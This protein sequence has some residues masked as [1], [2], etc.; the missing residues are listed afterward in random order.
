MKLKCSMFTVLFHRFCL[1]VSFPRPKLSRSLLVHFWA[2]PTAPVDFCYQE[3][4]T[5]ARTSKWPASQRNCTPPWIQPTSLQ[6]NTT[7]AGPA[8]NPRRLLPLRRKKPLSEPVSDPTHLWVELL[9]YLDSASQ[10]PSHGPCHPSSV[11][12]LLMNTAPNPS[13][14]PPL[15]P[16]SYQ[17]KQVQA[18]P[19]WADFSDSVQAMPVRTG[20]GHTTQK[21]NSL[22]HQR[23][24]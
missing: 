5:P 15:R 21:N 23:S 12:V 20:A 19:T 24:S 16:T 7:T 1:L 4:V 17:S 3:Q 9:H 11:L 6:H 22:L 18:T 13:G 14:L 10:E 2:L 8:P